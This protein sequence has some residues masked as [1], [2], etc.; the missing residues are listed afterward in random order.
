MV[1]LSASLLAF[2]YRADAEPTYK[3]F[4]WENGGYAS[5]DDLPALVKKEVGPRASIA[6]WD[7]IKARYGKNEAELKAFCHKLGLAP[8]GSAWVTQAGKRF[9]QEQRH[10][11]IYRADH[12]APEDFMLHDQMQNN[13]LLLGSWY[14]SRPILVK[15]VDYNA[16]DA[17]KWANWDSMLKATNETVIAGV[18]SLVSID[19]KKVPATISHEGHVQEIRSG[20]FTIRPDGTCSSKITVGPPSGADRTVEVTATSTREGPRLKLQWAGAGIT[21]GLVQGNTFT[22]ENEG[23]VLVYR[24]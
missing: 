18:Y 19:G 16:T 24:K 3:L 22:M 7:D 10:Y 6:D 13:L 21:T 4:G 15:V 20:S 11:F 12:K 17:A 9:W 8:N 5:K 2:S 14:E 23:M 1:L